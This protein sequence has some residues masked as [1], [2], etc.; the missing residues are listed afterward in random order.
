VTR[1]DQIPAELKILPNWVCWKLETPD[2]KGRRKK[3]PINP[4]T[5]HLASVTDPAT[6]G[7][8]EQAV[9]HDHHHVGFV[10]TKE[11]GCIG[12][13]IDHCRD[14]QTFA[15]QPSAREIYL[16]LNSYTEISQSGSGL[17][18]IVKGAMPQDGRRSSALEVY[19]DGRYFCMTGDILPGFPDIR[20]CDRGS[21]LQKHFTGSQSDC[22]GAKVTGGR[23]V[24]DNKLPQLARE[25]LDTLGGKELVHV[26]DAGS[27]IKVGRN[28]TF[29]IV[30]QDK[31]Q[32][33]GVEIKGRGHRRHVG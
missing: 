29:R 16:E 30:E 2:A 6:L 12:V 18:I 13:D 14:P 28:R 31:F 20:E 32:L 19:S 1:L 5:G 24:P 3:K 8:F 15:I 22:R 4:H 17:H 11:C 10:F 23:V 21:F 7:T 9:A 27:N 26:M 25:L 33:D